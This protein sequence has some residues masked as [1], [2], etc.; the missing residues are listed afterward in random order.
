MKKKFS[1]T[2]E[3]CKEFFKDC[4]NR[5]E[6]KEKSR[7][8]W[9]FLREKDWLDE[10]IKK[11]P[12]KYTKEAC[13]KIAGECRNRTELAKRSP[14]AYRVALSEKFIKELK[15]KGDEKE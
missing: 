6:I 2:L 8:G 14:Q 5:T 10:I 1:K 11:K 15:F 4:K 12:S 9:D 3:E 7:A 13:Q